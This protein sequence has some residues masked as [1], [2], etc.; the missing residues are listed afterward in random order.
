MNA[1]MRNA[2]SILYFY[3]EWLKSPYLQYTR[4]EQYILGQFHNF[5]DVC[6]YLFLHW[7]DPQ[8]VLS[9]WALES[10]YPCVAVFCV[11]LWLISWRCSIRV[12][13]SRLCPGTQ[14]NVKVTYFHLYVLF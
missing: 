11:H 6:G 13:L 2:F 9:M 5:S 14:Q 10:L 8:A 3:R 1:N 7:D 4:F 12:V